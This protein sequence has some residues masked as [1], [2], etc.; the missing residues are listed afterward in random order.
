MVTNNGQI[1]VQG[2]GVGSPLRVAS[3]ATLGGT[4]EVL[5]SNAAT[6]GNTNINVIGGNFAFE[7]ATLTNSAGHTIRAI[8]PGNLGRDTTGITNNGLVVGDG[9][10]AQLVV[11]PNDANGAFTNNGT[12]RAQAGAVVTLRN[13]FDNT[14]GM[15]ESVSGGVVELDDAVVTG[16]QLMGSFT[17]TASTVSDLTTS[18]TIEVG[19]NR[20]LR[21]TGTITNNGQVRLSPDGVG[22]QLIPDADTTFAGTGEVL[23]NEVP[24]PGVISTIGAQFAASDVTLTNAAGHTF[25]ATGPG[26]LGR[27]TTGLVNHGEIVADGPNADLNF[28]PKNTTGVPVAGDFYNAGTIK[29]VNG[30]KLHIAVGGD[31]SSGTIEAIGAGSEVTK[32]NLAGTDILLGDLRAIDGGRLEVFDT[33]DDVSIQ[34]NTN[35]LEF[36]GMSFADIFD[37]TADSGYPGPSIGSMPG[38]LGSLRFFSNEGTFRISDGMNFTSYSQGGAAQNSGVIIAGAG[39]TFAMGGYGLGTIICGDPG[40]CS[41]PSLPVISVNPFT[42]TGTLAGTGTIANAHGPGMSGIIPINS[43][44]N[45][46]PVFEANLVSDGIISPGDDAGDTGTLT[47]VGYEIELGDSNVIEIE[48]GPGGADS[49]VLVT[50]SAPVDLNGELEITLLPGYT[51]SQGDTFNLITAANGVSGLFD[52]ET[53]APP[54]GSLVWDV[55]ISGGVVD[56]IA[57]LPGDYNDDGFVDAADYTVWRDNLGQA[58]GT[59]SNDIDGGVIGLGQYNTWVTN[60]GA[61]A[62]PALSASVPEPGAL[63]LISAVMVAAVSRRRSV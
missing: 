25:R 53:I 33:T 30:G 43:A 50:D 23:L 24:A 60:F 35:D 3:N 16:G 26:T 1:V 18:A 54:P 20:I 39:S 12:I 44:G 41:P 38:H 56:L 2:T 31:S 8:G 47:L 22:V 32:S 34:V 37:G 4:G 27:G 9:V 40:G 46:P 63:M 42:S 49:L 36:T 10:D 29:A 14:N 48:I 58:A 52:T 28:N 45:P 57:K 17:A 61:S 5:I 19:S 21:T 13:S 15:I 59:L 11:H 55:E 51:P 7:M 62:G 6:G